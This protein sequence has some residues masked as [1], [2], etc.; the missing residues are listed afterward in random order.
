MPFTRGMSLHH[1]NAHRIDASLWQG[2]WLT[3]HTI[4]IIT[5]R[6]FLV[7]VLGSAFYY[8]HNRLR[9]NFI[10]HHILSCPCAI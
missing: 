3:C 6:N 4:A 9:F 2:A 7:R 10:L 1:G 8:A 5:E